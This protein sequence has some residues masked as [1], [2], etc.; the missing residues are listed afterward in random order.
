MAQLK[1]GERKP[2]T[3]QSDVSGFALRCVF[4][5]TQGQPNFSTLS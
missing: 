5:I 3:D 4:Y 1:N 2:N